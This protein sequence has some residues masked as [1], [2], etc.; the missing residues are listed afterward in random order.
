MKLNFDL[1]STENAQTVFTELIDRYHLETYE[2]CA[3]MCGNLMLF[4]QAC[5]S[6]DGKKGYSTL[7]EV[8][9]NNLA[10]LSDLMKVCQYLFTESDPYYR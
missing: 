9:R 3:N 7:D 10:R 8:E 4:C 6:V 1:L 5:I 2:D